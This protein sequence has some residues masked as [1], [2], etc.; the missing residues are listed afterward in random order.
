[1]L[2]EK[3]KYDTMDKTSP[4]MSEFTNCLQEE[5]AKWACVLGCNICKIQA[6][7]KLE[8]YYENPEDNR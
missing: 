7:L 8:S 5:A 2:L 4:Q 1:M 3:I 6:N